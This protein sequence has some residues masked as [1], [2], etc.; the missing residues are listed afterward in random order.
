MERTTWRH[1]QFE[2]KA[3][4]PQPGWL[5]LPV[6]RLAR[7]GCF[8]PRICLHLS[9]LRGAARVFID[10]HG[11]GRDDRPAYASR[12]LRQLTVGIV[13]TQAVSGRRNAE[14]LMKFHRD[15]P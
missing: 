5:I 12:T 9:K 1:L 14:P 15:Y 4:L 11:A 13:S 6:R 3:C 7:R 10:H 8:C 2:G